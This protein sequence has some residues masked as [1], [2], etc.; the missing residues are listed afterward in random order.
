M[1][2]M[3]F[4]RLGLPVLLLMLNCFIVTCDDI[5]IN[6]WHLRAPNSPYE[7]FKATVGD[8]ITFFWS[9]EENHTVYIN[10]TG[11][12]NDTGSILVGTSSPASYTFL[13]WDA[14]K[15]EPN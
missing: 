4:L 1:S 8:T 13:E 9:L 15:H 6:P 3:R 5:F 12:C 7:N 10:P 14:H 11:N 2:A